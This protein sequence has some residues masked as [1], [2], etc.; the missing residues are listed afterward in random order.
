[1]SIMDEATIPPSGGMSGQTEAKRPG[2]PADPYRIQQALWRGKRWLIGATVGGLIAGLVVAK[3]VM[4]SDYETT[5]VLKYDGDVEVGDLQ[6]SRYALGPAADALS[7]QSVL[8]RVREET[9]LDATLTSLGKWIVYDVDFRSGTLRFSV[10]GETGEEAAEFAHIVTDILLAYHKERQSRRIENEIARTGKRIGA[11]EREAEEARERYNEFREKHGIAHLSTEQQSMVQSAAS[12]RAVSELAG[13]EIRALEAQVKSLE[14]HLVSTPKTNFVSEGSSP[15][16][17]AYNRLRHEL[18]SASATLSPEHPRVQALEQQVSQMRSRLQAGGGPNSS[19]GGL[20]AVNAT[21]QAVQ[22]Q[23][24]QAQ[25]NLAALRERQKGLS[26]M[27]DKAQNRVEAFSD[28]EGKASGL[29]AEVT[30]NEALLSGLQATEA[31]LEDALRDPPS[32]FS[33]LDPGAVPEYPIR[34]K[35]KLVAFVAIIALSILFALLFVL[36]REFRGLLLKTPTEV[37]FWGNGPVV[38]ATAWPDDPPGLDEL[39]AGLDDFAPEARGN[40]L[41]LGASP[42]EGWLATELAHRLDSDW[43]PTQYRPS[44]VPST[45]SAPPVERGPLQTPPP[46]GPYPLHG[47]GSPSTAAA[48]QAQRASTPPSQ[49]AAAQPQRTSTP[50]S[51]ALR[52]ISRARLVRF[53]AWQGPFEGQ[54]LRRAA[55]LA[56]RVVVLVRSGALSAPQLHKLR[57][58]LGRETGIGYLVVGLPDEFRTLPD[59][60]GNVAAFWNA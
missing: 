19:G 1:M 2:F 7:R 25:S 16:R 3:L 40:M 27:A 43:F 47:A 60:A 46:S 17:A 24:R 14:A 18:A 49:A 22:G 55:R 50:P 34:N 38:A 57:H 42:G 32:G 44:S 48:T 26:G 35:M 56:D 59:R 33:V 4:V 10:T 23:L 54:A 39:V 45:P 11:A 20:V 12:L 8:R 31:A 41:V 37:A 51:E 21:Y 9:G 6:S 36:W 15:E 53:E 29:L 52:V 28:I 30:V 58:R 5:V 13:S